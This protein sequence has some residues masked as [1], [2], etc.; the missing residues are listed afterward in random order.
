MSIYRVILCAQSSF[1][2]HPFADVIVASSVVDVILVPEGFEHRS[3]QHCIKRSSPP[4][5]VVL[6]IPIGPAALSA[7]LHQWIGS[8]NVFNPESRVLLIG[9][10]GALSDRLH[11]GDGV[12]MEMCGQQLDGKDTHW[13]SCDRALTAAIANRAGGLQSG[14]LIT[15]AGVVCSRL[16]K[17]RLGRETQADVVDMEGFTALEILSV[18]GHHVAI[19]RVVSDDRDHDLPDL[20]LAVSPSGSV[21]ALPLLLACLKRPL[22]AIRLISGSLQALRALS[23]LTQQLFGDAA[24]REA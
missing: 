10:G 15:T 11:V 8:G 5:P 12:L 16:E 18:A 20:A 7:H 13:I 6:A 19:L 23:L 24:R 1:V 4:L 9:L 21:Q 14:R 2:D 22:A 3:V 17:L